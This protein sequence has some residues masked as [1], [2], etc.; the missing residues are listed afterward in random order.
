MTGN[1]DRSVQ[2]LAIVPVI[3]GREAVTAGIGRGERPDVD[4][5]DLVNDRSNVGIG[6]DAQ[7]PRGELH[8]ECSPGMLVVV[9]GPSEA[10]CFHDSIKLPV[11][12]SRLQDEIKVRGLVLSSAVERRTRSTSKD[13]PDLRASQCPRDTSGDLCQGGS[14]GESQSR[15]PARRGRFLNSAVRATRPASAAARRLR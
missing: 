4:P 14:R 7:G 3:E 2:A 11:C 5:T 1:L 8:E 12:D 10:D 6:A 15:F 13:R 9:A